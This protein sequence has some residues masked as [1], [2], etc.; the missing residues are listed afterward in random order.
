MREMRD[1]LRR[2]FLEHARLRAGLEILVDETPDAAFGVDFVHAVLLDDF[3]EVAAFAHPVALLDDAA[4]HVDEVEATVGAVGHVDDAEIAVGGA[5]E[6]GFAVRVRDRGEAVFHL[7][8]RAADEAADGLGNEHVA[9][10]F[11]G[12]AIAADD[13]L[14]AGRGEVVH[15][16]VG[17]ADAA[18]AA[19]EIREADERP[20]FIEVGRELAGEIVGAVKDRCLEMPEAFFA[21]GVAPPEFAVVV[22]REA[23]LAAAGGCIF[24]ERRLG[25]IP[26]EA[27]GIGRL[28]DP[29]VEGPEEAALL[30]LEVSAACA[31]GEPELFFV[32]D[33][34]AIRVLVGDDVVG[35]GFVDEHAFVEREDHAG[36]LELVAEDG[37]F[38]EAAIA[39]GGL[40]AGDDAD[41]DE[42]ILA[43]DVLHVAAHLS[44][45]HAAIAVEGEVD[46]FADAVALAEDQ[47]EGVA[48]RELDGLEFLLGREGFKRGLGSEVRDV[49]GFVGG[50]N[51]RSCRGED[52]DGSEDGRDVHSDRSS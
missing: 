18:G 37:V 52:G 46:G 30:M 49:F 50:K 35:V 19:L 13:F 42:F 4:I 9:A 28:V 23:P 27:K 2:C 31:A 17:S 20:D 21:A 33:A 6:L 8:F 47:F 43:V 10:Q 26:A 5:D 11:G 14:A 34:V 51:L 32:G 29:V 39:L 44:E 1:E 3:A 22:L 15:G 36:E 24:L 45:V 16:L 40:V 41:R 38:V 12:E 7:D 48:G 25:A